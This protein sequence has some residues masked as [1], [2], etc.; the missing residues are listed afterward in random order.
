MQDQLSAVFRELERIW[1]ASLTTAKRKRYNTIKV[2]STH[3]SSPD[4][5]SKAPYNFGICANWYDKYKDTYADWISDWFTYED[6]DGFGSKVAQPSGEETEP[7]DGGRERSEA[8]F[9]G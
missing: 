7:I 4:P 8:E 9:D 1:W 3:R 2:I 6:I 5:P